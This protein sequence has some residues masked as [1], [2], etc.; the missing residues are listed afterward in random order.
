MFLIRLLFALT[1]PVCEETIIRAFTQTELEYLLRRGP[2]IAAVLSAFLQA[3]YHLYQG[4]FT[5]LVYFA[6]FLVSA[7]YYAR[8]RRAGPVITAHLLFDVLVVLR[9]R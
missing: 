7:A 6:M 8:W 5:A 2:W 9:H 4:V 1:N 3:A